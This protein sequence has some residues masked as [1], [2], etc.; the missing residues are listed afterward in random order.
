M[1]RQAF[2]NQDSPAIVPTVTKQ[3]RG[4]DVYFTLRWS[5]LQKV[6]KYAIINTV[7]A[8]AGIFELYYL[9][10][11]KKLVMMRV[12]RV[13]YGGLRSR[14]RSVTDPDLNDDER[15]KKIL[16]ERECYFRYTIIGTFGDMQD[17]L[18]FF[19]SRYTPKHITVEHSGRYEE[20]YVEE[21]SPNKIVTTG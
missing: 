12:A 15:H 7:P 4:N 6:D 3:I 16:L 8:E 1:S 5:P 2:M 20:I 17:L 21:K 19:A 11:K 13:W 14:L 9:D 18:F 10:D